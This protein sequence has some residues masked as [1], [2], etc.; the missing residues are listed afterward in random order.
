[1]ANWLLVEPTDI[2]Q[3]PTERAKYIDRQAESVAGARIGV[4]ASWWGEDG[5]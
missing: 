2:E 1:L 5:I 3:V 4:W